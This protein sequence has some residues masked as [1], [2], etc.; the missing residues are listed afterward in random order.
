MKGTSVG[1]REAV[2][3]RLEMFS[4]GNITELPRS[5]LMV[6]DATERHDYRNGC[7][8]ARDCHGQVVRHPIAVPSL[9]PDVPAPWT[10]EAYLAGRDPGMEAVA[11]AVAADRTP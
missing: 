6:L 3:D 7:R 2:G 5:G 10:V 9:A 4:E 1:V 11:A 8:A